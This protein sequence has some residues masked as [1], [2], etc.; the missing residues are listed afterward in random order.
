MILHR[1][2][3]NIRL[4]VFFRSSTLTPVRYIASS[5][6]AF[7]SINPWVASS[8]SRLRFLLRRL[9]SIRSFFRYESAWS[10]LKI[11]RTT[12]PHSNTLTLFVFLSSGLLKINKRFD[13]RECN[14]WK[15]IGIKKKKNRI[16]RITGVENFVSTTLRIVLVRLFFG[17][18]SEKSS[19]RMAKLALAR[20][21]FPGWSLQL[22]TSPHEW[23]MTGFKD[24]RIL[25]YEELPAIVT[26]SYLR[27]LITGLGQKEETRMNRR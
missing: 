8:S 4:G 13:T 21:C 6:L 15:W 20:V 17:S 3:D 10:G 1:K 25:P 14:G 26:S 9:L 11:D 18:H 16:T 19:W 24:T 12:D 7:T 5:V 2:I 23:I 27:F 22:K